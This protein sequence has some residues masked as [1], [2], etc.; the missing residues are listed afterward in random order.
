MVVDAP[1]HTQQG[2]ILAL[3]VPCPGPHTNS[4][5][6]SAPRNLSLQSANGASSLHRNR[7]TPT[8]AGEDEPCH[9]VWVQERAWGRHLL[10]APGLVLLFGPAPGYSTGAGGGEPGPLPSPRRG[11]PRHLQEGGVL[12][13]GPP[14]GRARAQAATHWHLRAAPPPCVRGLRSGLAGGPPLL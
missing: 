7:S 1:G 11:G 10:P 13:P 4:E 9:R 6:Y 12:C 14:R 5:A 3:Q 2:T 8:T